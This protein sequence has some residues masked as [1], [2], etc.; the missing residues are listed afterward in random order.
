MRVKSLVCSSLL[1][2]TVALQGCKH[3]LAIVGEG[4]IVEVGNSG[5]GCTLEQFRAGD[6]TCTENEV[7]GDY[8]VN[9][10]AVPRP[11]WRF[12]R[13]EGPCP[14]DSDFQHCQFR[15]AK[16]A[17]AWWE[18]NSPDRVIP[19]STAVFQPIEGQTGYLLAGNPVAGVA[20]NTQTQEGV[21]GLDGSFQYEEGE[22]VR[23][24]IGETVLGTVRGRARVTPFELAGTPVLSATTISLQ[25]A[26]PF[27]VISLYPPQTYTWQEFD[28]ISGD[29]FFQRADPFDTVT[30]ITVLVQSLDEDAISGNGIVIR[31]G[32]ADLFRGIR[33]ELRQRENS[34]PGEMQAAGT[35]GDF[36][37]L[38]YKLAQ[39]NRNQLF[40]V[41]H[42]PVKPA[43]ALQRLYKALGLPDRTY[44]I[45]PGGWDFDDSRVGC[46]Y[47]A[48][49][50]LVW[51]KLES[52]AVTRY[53]YDTHGNLTW[54]QTGQSI[55]T[56]QYNTLGDP[57]QATN[58]DDGDGLPE[59]IETW[60][61]DQF[62][63]VTRYEE[64]D[65][66]DNTVDH[67]IT[68]E[69][70]V[71][72][73]PVR[74]EEHGDDPREGAH[75][76]W[77]YHT[78]GSLKQYEETYTVDT[79]GYLS[80]HSQEWE[81]DTRGRLILYR[82]DDDDT[83]DIGVRRVSVQTREYDDQGNFLIK[84]DEGE[85]GLSSLPRA[86]H[87]QFDDAG[88]LTRY[89]R[90]NNLDGKR[91]ELQTWQYDA[92][93]RV[94]RY[95]RD[96]GFD[97]QPDYIEIWRYAADG[98]TV[99]AEG[100]DAAGQQIYSRRWQYNANH[101]LTRYT[102]DGSAPTDGSSE[103]PAPPLVETWQYNPRGD[104]TRHTTNHGDEQIL[105]D[106]WLYDEDGN[107]TRFE[108]N[109]NLTGTPGPIESWQFHTTG[110][111]HLFDQPNLGYLYF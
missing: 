62:G 36:P 45:C 35:P 21:T 26:L 73:K 91:E 78:N 6:T 111:G 81:Y 44:A 79:N 110:W 16:E 85:E 19:P 76:S 61:Y 47:D 109:Y 31:A 68:S 1:L 100:T 10:Q 50:N 28:G 107:L 39:A 77:Q 13:W 37:T 52:G 14:P 84:E 88:R 72:G 27:S 29:Y 33:L 103:E 15:L 48:N 2:A 55:Q 63:N 70:D 82:R 80:N 87:Y 24:S 86:G 93:G 4:D 75:Q 102:Q 51:L 65:G 5:R 46:R 53:E 54:Q 97:S 64:G 59:R 34:L 43:V 12:V 57:V 40:S 96:V 98:R 67:V 90:D 7:S 60:Q 3:P 56:W 104:L 105:I 69:Y 106:S 101:K 25:R 66:I 94:V 9:Y 92:R 38:R 30:N 8:F 74:T 89:T 58:D 17:V 49:G 22:T 95:M 32:V 99:L 11:G 83:E 42:G 71:Q 20:Y 41:A 18:Q 108:R 23:F